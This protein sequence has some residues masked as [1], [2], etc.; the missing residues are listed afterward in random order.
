MVDMDKYTSKSSKNEYFDKLF[1]EIAKLRQNVMNIKKVVGNLET[2]NK[3][4]EENM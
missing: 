3:I 1:K 2:E 4:G